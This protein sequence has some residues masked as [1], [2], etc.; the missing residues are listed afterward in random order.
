MRTTTRTWSPLAGVV[1]MAG[2]V[3]LLAACGASAQQEQAVN[4]RYPV[5]GTPARAGVTA[6]QVVADEDVVERITWARCDR[7]Q[8]CNLIGPGATY[9]NRNE[10][11]RQ[12]RAMV[13]RDINPARCKGGVGEIGV[14][15]C[16]KSL[17]DGECDMPG[18]IAG[19]SADCNLAALC[20]RQ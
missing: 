19:R 14:G 20:I 16:V 3:G 5:P 4:A 9:A 17:I 13:Q 7:D 18:Q 8:S 10:C 11:V 2:V 12:T 1:G 15:K 6:Q